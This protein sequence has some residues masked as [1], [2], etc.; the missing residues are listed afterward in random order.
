[1]PHLPV[2]G[3]HPYL[4]IG[5][6]QTAA[7]NHAIAEAAR[8]GFAAIEIP[9][10]DPF[11]FDAASHRAALKQAG[12]EPLCTVSLPRALHLPRTPERARAWLGHA[13]AAA[14]AVGS[15]QLGGAL[16]YAMG[17][18]SSGPATAQEK[19]LVVE[20]LKDL[21][22]E[23]RARGITLGLAPSNRYGTYLF[24]TLDDVRALIRAVG[25][26]NLV[27]HAD[28]YHMNIEESNFRTA[29]VG[30]GKLLRSLAISESNR[31]LPGSGTVQWEEVWTGLGQIDYDGYLV[32]KTFAAIAPDLAAAWHVWK[33]PAS[34]S[35]ALAAQGL[36]FLRAGIA[37]MS[38]P[39]KP[40]A[41]PARSTSKPAAKTT[42]KRS[43]PR[44]QSTAATSG[45]A[46]S[47]AEGAAAPARQRAPRKRS[48]TSKS[49][50]S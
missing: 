33:Q 4:L 49:Y 15:T 26:P 2:L 44:K 41:R 12:V 27:I 8:L 31:G 9:I 25:A 19:Q 32:L 43:T 47:P 39:A 34:P 37:A 3:V 46:E 40:A 5:A 50:R 20:V 22:A 28:T 36:A 30:A 13:L 17:E 23:A 18:L 10:A 21:C 38:T 29:I 45:A 1:M 14:E 6:W 24:N 48:T 7:G 35:D 16:A 11:H 42:R